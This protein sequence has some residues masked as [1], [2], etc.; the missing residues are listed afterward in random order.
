MELKLTEQLPS[1]TAIDVLASALIALPGGEAA[2]EA[3][4]AA[5]EA[6]EVDATETEAAE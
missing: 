1:N 2:L 6:V 5:A 4:I 3:A